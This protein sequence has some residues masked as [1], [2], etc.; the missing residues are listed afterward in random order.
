MFRNTTYVYAVSALFAAPLF[1]MSGLFALEYENPATREMEQLAR[2]MEALK[3]T[4]T[5]RKMYEELLSRLN[6]YEPQITGLEAELSRLQTEFQRNEDECYRDWSCYYWSSTR[7]GSALTGTHSLYNRR[8]SELNAAMDNVKSQL[9][10]LKTE[11]IA[12]DPVLK[13]YG[14]TDYE[15]LKSS[16]E[17][18]KQDA[19]SCWKILE[20]IRKT[21][22]SES[23]KAALEKCWYFPQVP[24]MRR[25]EHDAFQRNVCDPLNAHCRPRNCP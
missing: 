18:Y 10:K 25:P 23:V 13:E 20:G 11:P 5:S 24:S 8:K 12:A 1:F 7:V 21:C 2:S 3:A 4:S 9:V 17:E 6:M 22:E 15:L 16:V 19:D 14:I